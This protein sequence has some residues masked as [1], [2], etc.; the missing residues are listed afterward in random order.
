MSQKKSYNRKPDFQFSVVAILKITQNAQFIPKYLCL[1]HILLF[2]RVPK[3]IV[4]GL[5]YCQGIHSRPLLP[6]I[7]KVSTTEKIQIISCQFLHRYIFVLPAQLGD[8]QGSLLQSSSAAASVVAASS[9]SSSSSNFQAKIAPKLQ[10]IF[11][12]NLECH[13][14][15]P[16][17]FFTFLGVTGSCT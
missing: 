12:S 15:F 10:I 14:V 1:L 2:H 17:R 9:A 8:I 4:R 3:T 13:L 7:D 11:G 16:V 5:D 6:K